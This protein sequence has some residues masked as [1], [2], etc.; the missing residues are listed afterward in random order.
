MRHLSNTHKITEISD[1][2]K[3]LDKKLVQQD[4]SKMKMSFEKKRKH[5][6]W[7]T[8]YIVVGLLPFKHVE[9]E[10]IYIVTIRY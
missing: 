7:L 1:R 3:N 8:E 10:G 4:I 9:S 2:D 5:D 6:S